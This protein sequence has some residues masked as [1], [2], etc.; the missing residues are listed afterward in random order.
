MDSIW[1]QILSDDEGSKDQ[2]LLSNKRSIGIGK[3]PNGLARNR[4]E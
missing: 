2:T 4:A 1:S 3:K